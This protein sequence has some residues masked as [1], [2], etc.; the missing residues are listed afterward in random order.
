MRQTFRDTAGKDA[1]MRH[2]D[3]QTYR[4][5]KAQA[6]HIHINFACLHQTYIA[7]TDKQADTESDKH[8]S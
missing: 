6:Y 5:R 4:G 8:T 1:N 3:I 2:T 7:Q